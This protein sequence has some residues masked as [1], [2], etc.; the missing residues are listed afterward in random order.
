MDEKRV[1]HTAEASTLPTGIRWG[2]VKDMTDESLGAA[3]APAAG[4]GARSSRA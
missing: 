2:D 3:R 4:P 1:R